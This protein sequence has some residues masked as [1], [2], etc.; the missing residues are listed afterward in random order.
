MVR[1][2]ASTP[3][4]ASPWLP[5]PCEWLPVAGPDTGDVTRKQAI[6]CHRTRPY[7]N[8][9]QPHSGT[10][11]SGLLQRHPSCHLQLGECLASCFN[12]SAAAINVIN[13]F[14]SFPQLTLAKLK[15]AMQNVGLS[16]PVPHFLGHHQ[17]L[18]WTNHLNGNLRD[19]RRKDQKKNANEGT[20]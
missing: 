6:K 7:L 20:E 2:N 15:L 10:P 19:V 12:P 8:H 13:L 5:W 14:I 9:P 18:A 1:R 17:L 3:R 4:A 16:L 11:R